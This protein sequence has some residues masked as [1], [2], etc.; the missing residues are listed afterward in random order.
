MRCGGA[1]EKG[2]S[3]GARHN[4]CAKKAKLMVCVRCPPSLSMARSFSKAGS[5]PNR[6]R[7][8]RDERK[9]AVDWAAGEACGS[10]ARHRPLL[11]AERTSPQADPH[12]ERISPVR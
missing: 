10:E 1:A 3:G 7:C 9:A 8:L 2:C 6:Q 12:G 11:R 4:K 5:R